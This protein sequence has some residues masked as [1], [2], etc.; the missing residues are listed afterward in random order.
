[1]A[2][3]DA[4]DFEAFEQ[5]L[6]RGG[7]LRER[8]APAL[9][10]G[11]DRLEAPRHPAAGPRS[12]AAEADCDVGARSDDG[13][14]DRARHPVAG[15]AQRDG[16][17]CRARSSCS[18]GPGARLRRPGPADRRA[19]A[20]HQ[21]A[22]DG[23][24]RRRGARAATGRLGARRRHRLRVP[25][26]GDGGVR[27]TRREHRTDRAACARRRRSACAA[28]TTTSRSSTAT[29]SLGVPERAP[30]DAI[31]VGAAAPRLPVALARQL[32]EGGRLVIP[33]TDGR[34]GP[35]S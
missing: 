6:S 20:D 2:A 11:V 3:L 9:A 18:R 4:H 28:S 27:R 12:D 33:I 15:R 30:F 14:A 1:M 8:A 10:E 7:R 22:A 35:R 29:A 16:A 23:R 13:V 25:G 24:G 31:A 26:G 19:G 32:V 34:S 21:P 17:A 5:P